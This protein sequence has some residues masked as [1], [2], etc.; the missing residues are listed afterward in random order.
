[1]GTAALAPP[2]RHRWARGQTRR[3]GTAP[4]QPPLPCSSGSVGSSRK[5]QRWEQQ[6]QRWR[7]QQ[8]QTPAANRSI[9]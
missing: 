1:M 3:G 7:R 9:R 2:R 6:Q 5:H 4:Q 8:Q